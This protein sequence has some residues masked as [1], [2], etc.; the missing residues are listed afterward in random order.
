MSE[1]ATRAGVAIECR[2]VTVRF[3]SDRG[4]VTALANV[5]VALAEGGFLTL[6]DRPAAVSQHYCA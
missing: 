6:L 1:T 2:D 5:S 4:S 3:S